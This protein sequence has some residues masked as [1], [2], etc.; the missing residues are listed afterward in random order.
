MV[1]MT[2]TTTI[3]NAVRSIFV[4]LDGQRVLRT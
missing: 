1:I 4:G 2:D 3:S